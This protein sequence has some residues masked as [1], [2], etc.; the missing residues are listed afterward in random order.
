MTG[1]CFLR[2]VGKD[3]FLLSPD[4]VKV[5]RREKVVKGN[6]TS[7]RDLRAVQDAFNLWRRQSGRP[8]CHLSRIVAC[9]VV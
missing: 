6:A 2:E 7:K 1:P 9:S 5:L 8:L 3:T 4:V